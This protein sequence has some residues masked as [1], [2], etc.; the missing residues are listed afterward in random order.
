VG[1]VVEKFFSNVCESLQK[2][3]VNLIRPDFDVHF[4]S[5][6]FQKKCE[7]M[8]V[9]AFKKLYMHGYRIFA[10]TATFDSTFRITTLC[11]KFF[12]LLLVEIDYQ[13]MMGMQSG[14]MNR[15]P[16]TR[17]FRAFDQGKKVIPHRPLLL[18]RKICNM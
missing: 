6:T 11:D 16:E 13:L 9:K 17:Q 10:R 7:K 1:V 18:R 5:F 12:A 8:S 14:H 3:R 2:W 15:V 4:L